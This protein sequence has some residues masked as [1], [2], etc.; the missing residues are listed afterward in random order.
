MSESSTRP[1]P[2]PGLKLF[3][4]SPQSRSVDRHAYA[5]RVAE[6]ARWSEAA[7]CEGILVYT[8]NGIVD[9]WLVAQLILQA[10]EQICPLIAV[11]PTYMHPYSVAKMIASLAHLHRR[12]VYLNLVAGG[13]RRDLE[14]LGDH[15]AH[16]ERYRRALEYGQIITGLAAGGA[17]TLQGD[18]YNVRNLWLAP[19]IDPGFEPGLMISGSSPAGMA[20]AAELGA[21]SIKYPQPSD[22]EPAHHDELVEVGMRIGVIA[23]D[24]A[25][26]A[27]EI[28]HTRFPDDRAGRIAQ[29]LAG[30]VSD[31]SWHHQLSALVGERTRSVYW[32]GPF[33][34]Y[35]SFCPYLVGDY[36]T[37]AQELARYL[38]LGFSTF[39]LDIPRVEE[40]LRHTIQAFRHAAALP[41]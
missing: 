37:V 25:V 23:R 35:A 40:D 39:V 7:G 22:L 1:P 9:P 4:T 19:P 24:D 6:I 3:S 38:G 33:E 15:T 41:R 12:R 18:F 31:S 28:A 8:E 20:V 16:D 10:T 26:E 32:L 36:E 11:Q 2:V 14:A 29:R 17:F 34:N 27:W 13:F 21:I 5:E 30:R